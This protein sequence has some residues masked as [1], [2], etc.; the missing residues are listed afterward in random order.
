MGEPTSTT[1][2]T[3]TLDTPAEQPPVPDASQA[4]ERAFEA[5]QRLLFE[6]IELARL[7]LLDGL[8]S[9]LR[10]AVLAVA[11]ALGGW[12]M[13]L[14]ALVLV[15]QAWMPGAAALGLVGALQL[16]VAAATVS[17]RARTAGRPEESR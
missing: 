17:G 7:E 5:A 6:R 3:T 2:D 10:T 1:L 4:M 12:G 14:A 8:A 11:L 9:L 15:L 16:V 13:L